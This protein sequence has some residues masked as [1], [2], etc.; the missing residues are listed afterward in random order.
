MYFHMPAFM[1]KAFHTSV[2]IQCQCQSG[3][4][5]HGLS[6]ELCH[7]KIALQNMEACFM[8]ITLFSYSDKV[9]VHL[10]QCLAAHVCVCVCV[11]VRAHAH[12]C[13]LNL[14]VYFETT[15]V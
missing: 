14:L 13:M 1:G 11:C 6:D 8:L 7:F 2:F 5:T 3:L 12:A 15:F 9:T 4:A 10:G